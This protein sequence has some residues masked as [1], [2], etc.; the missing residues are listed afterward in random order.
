MIGTQDFGWKI[1]EALPGF[2]VEACKVNESLTLCGSHLFASYKLVF[3][4][5][6][7]CL[8]ALTYA[9]FPGT[10]GQVY[11]AAVI[12][13]GAHR[14]VTRRLLSQVERQCKRKMLQIGTT[15]QK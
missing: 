8:R 5:E 11:R 1:G 4:I 13:S 6:G 2:R 3:I 7:E 10:L 12:G 15:G 9:D 14:I